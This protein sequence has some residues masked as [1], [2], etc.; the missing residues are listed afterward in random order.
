MRFYKP[1]V[2]LCWRCCVPQHRAT[3]L[4]RLESLPCTNMLQQLGL[5]NRWLMLRTHSGL[6]QWQAEWRMGASPGWKA[7]QVC[8]NLGP[9]AVCCWHCSCIGQHAS[10]FL[11]SLLQGSPDETRVANNE[12]RS[13]STLG[14]TGPNAKYFCVPSPQLTRMSSSGKAPSGN[15]TVNCFGEKLSS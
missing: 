11:T 1:L 10:V 14:A 13:G 15:I 4:R 8:L 5:N 3:K 6:L 2:W 12:T 7:P 9:R